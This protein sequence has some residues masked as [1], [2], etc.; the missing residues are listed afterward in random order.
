MHHGLQLLTHLPPLT[1]AARYPARGR[2]HLLDKVLAYGRDQQVLQR[3]LRRG[4][5]CLKKRTLYTWCHCA[6]NGIQ[7][8]VPE[9]R[10]TNEA[11]VVPEQHKPAPLLKLEQLIHATP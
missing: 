3:V 4:N 8:P 2:R 9:A 10:V 11:A 1:D 5:P 7:Q 6:Q